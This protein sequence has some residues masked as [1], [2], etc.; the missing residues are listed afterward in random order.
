M[1]WKTEAV[2]INKTALPT[3]DNNAS[4]IFYFSRESSEDQNKYFDQFVEEMI[5]LSSSHRAEQ[6]SKVTPPVDNFEPIRS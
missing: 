5:L 3:F 2:R 4:L 6:L 1:I